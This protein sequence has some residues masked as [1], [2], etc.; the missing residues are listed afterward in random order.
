[1][2]YI[3]K[4]NLGH[5]EAHREFIIKLAKLRSFSCGDGCPALFFSILCNFL[6]S[7]PESEPY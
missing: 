5:A 7:F 6:T 3:S 2:D 4:G 1:M